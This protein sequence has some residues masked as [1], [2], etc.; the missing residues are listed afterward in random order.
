[1][2]AYLCL[3][4]I[5]KDNKPEITGAAIYSESADSITSVAGEHY[6]EL[7]S[8]S[9]EYAQAR[10]DILT[11]LRSMPRRFSWLYQYFE[12]LK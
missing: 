2:S 1:M 3:T 10:Q 4:I 6:A 9:G 8:C 12:E 11:S 7:F 5:V